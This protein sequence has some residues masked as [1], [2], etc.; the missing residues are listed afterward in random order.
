M[1]TELWLLCASGLLPCGLRLQ[2]EAIDDSVAEKMSAMFVTD[3]WLETLQA[4]RGRTLTA[5]EFRSELTNLMRWRLE[6]DLRY[7]TS[8]EFKVTNTSG[9]RNFRHDLCHRPPSRRASAEAIRPPCAP[10]EEA[11]VVAMERDRLNQLLGIL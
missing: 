3:L 9:P 6:R 7:K 4:R 5:A 8:L 10:R 2:T 11:A 1:G